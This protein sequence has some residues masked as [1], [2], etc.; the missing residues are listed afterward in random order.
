[1]RAYPK[2]EHR[3]DCLFGASDENDAGSSTAKRD[4]VV[5]I[6]GGWSKSAV[7][8]ED[9]RADDA[10]RERHRSGGTGY[11]RDALLTLAIDRIWKSAGLSRYDPDNRL[12]SLSAVERIYDAA[13]RIQTPL[14]PLADRL[15]AIAAASKAPGAERHALARPPTERLVLLGELGAWPEGEAAIQR[16]FVKALERSTGWHVAWQRPLAESIQRRFGWVLP[17]LGDERARV[18]FIGNVERGEDGKTLWPVRASL[19]VTSQGFMPVESSYELDLST[20]LEGTARRFRR[21]EDRRAPIVPDFELLDVNENEAPYVLEVFGLLSD[22]AYAQ[23]AEEKAAFY[24]EAYG[25]TGWWA[26][27]VGQG[28]PPP[29]PGACFPSRLATRG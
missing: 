11:A 6:E 12:N 21:A 2:H 24:D 15:V 29:L 23:H 27:R 28:D 10:A 9:E 13:R 5:R 20:Y 25:K 8:E 14:G 19:F 7:R 26:W 16:V 22:P 17:L 4:D 3:D 18:W 1:M